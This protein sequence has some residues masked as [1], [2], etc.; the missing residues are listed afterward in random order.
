MRILAEKSWNLVIPR[1][2]SP[3]IVQ[4]K[5]GLSGPLP[6]FLMSRGATL[7]SLVFDRSNASVALRDFL[8][9]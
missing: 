5:R 2:G 6:F 8:K 1:E 9:T 3:Q 7:A 4:H